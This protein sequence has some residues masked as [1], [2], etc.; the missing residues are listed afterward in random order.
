MPRFPIELIPQVVEARDSACRFNESMRALKAILPPNA[1]RL[2]LVVEEA[3]TTAIGQHRDLYESA[4]RHG[5]RATVVRKVLDS[6]GDTEP[7]LAYAAR[8]GNE[9]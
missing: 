4:E 5:V 9:S 1:R 3:H 8:P 2:V 7:D 6:L